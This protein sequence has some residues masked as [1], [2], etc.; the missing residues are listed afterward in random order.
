M[1]DDTIDEVFHSL[2][3]IGSLRENE[4]VRT[5]CG[6]LAIDRTGNLQFLM[7]WWYKEERILNI[8]AVSKVFTNAFSVVDTAFEKEEAY[9]NMHLG[10]SRRGHIERL[11]NW[12]LLQRSQ[13]E[14]QRGSVGLTNM[15]VTYKDDTKTTARIELLLEKIAGKLEQINE[16]LEYIKNNSGPMLS[17]TVQE[18]DANTKDNGD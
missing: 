11:N 17:S 15:L 8:Q 9:R 18:H 16:S 14:L 10:T 4:R 6:P 12:Q 5:Q 2:K 1:G 3:V 7:R 13:R